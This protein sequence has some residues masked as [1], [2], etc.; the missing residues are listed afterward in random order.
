METSEHTPL[1]VASEHTPL[2]METSEHTPL[3]METSEHT[4]LSVASEHTPL[5]METSEH[6]PLSMETSEH[7]P[8]PV[9]TSVQPPETLEKP[10]QREPEERSLPQEPK[11]VRVVP[12]AAAINTHTTAKAPLPPTKPDGHA[13]SV[14]DFRRLAMTK[15]NPENVL[16]PIQN[17]STVNSN[18]GKKEP[19]PAP[20]AAA[21]RKVGEKFREPPAALPPVKKPRL[22]TPITPEFMRREQQKKLLKLQKQQQQQQSPTKNQTKLKK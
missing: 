7:A 15:K 16:K 19:K 12:R 20:P 3:S 14:V 8:L 4:P 9:E 10:I 22:T 17:A 6:T 1:S 11:L 13:R 21:P 2:S 5:S 18:L